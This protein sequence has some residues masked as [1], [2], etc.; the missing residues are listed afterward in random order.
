MKG[1]TLGELSKLDYDWPGNVRELKQ[2][3]EKILNVVRG[4]N[5]GISDFIGQM[6]AVRESIS[7]Q[8]FTHHQEDD[9]VKTNVEVTK[10]DEIV[11]SLIRAHRSINQRQVQEEFGFK[12]TAA[13]NLLKKMI[14]KGLIR[15]V[16]EGRS[17][18]YSLSDKATR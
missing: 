18:K 1:G 7:T 6:V 17:Q 2:L 10:R 14:V 3:I 11:L 4:R 13:W 9:Q 8:D 15:S 16:G 5:I 12:S